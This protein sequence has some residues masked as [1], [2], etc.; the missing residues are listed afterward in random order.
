MNWGEQPQVYDSVESGGSTSNFEAN[1]GEGEKLNEKN[2]RQRFDQNEGKTLTRA[3]DKNSQI[4]K[5]QS[6]ETAPSNDFTIFKSIENKPIVTAKSTSPRP[7][8]ASSSI[9]TFYK[10]SSIFGLTNK[11][12]VTGIS[13]DIYPYHGKNHG[14]NEEYVQTQLRQMT[15]QDLRMEDFDHN[16]KIKASKSSKNLNSTDLIDKIQYAYELQDGTDLH[17]RR[18]IVFHSLSN[19]EY[20]TCGELLSDR[21]DEL[22]GRYNV[23]RRERRTTAEEFEAEVAEREELVRGKKDSVNNDMCRL[24]S[25]GEGVIRGK[26]G[27]P[28][29]LETFRR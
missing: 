2:T 10:P 23:A 29:A 15:Y 18:E 25:A 11:S 13:K 16:H 8:Q 27:N 20:E 3:N 1:N 9:S 5:D 4:P 12:A 21:L 19:E 17:A 6:Q 28:D 22:I 14:K 7:I 26:R 24:K